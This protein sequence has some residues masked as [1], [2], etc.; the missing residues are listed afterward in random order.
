MLKMRGVTAISDAPD[1]AL[2]EVCADVPERR[3]FP[4]SFSTMNTPRLCAAFPRPFVLLLAGFIG[5]APLSARGQFA[6]LLDTTSRFAGNSTGTGGYNQD[7]GVAT[8]T[9]LNVPSYIVFD[10]FG[11]L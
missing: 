2:R 6:T 11:N 4:R 1:T 3:S 7:A 9:S 5:L 10:S 8:A